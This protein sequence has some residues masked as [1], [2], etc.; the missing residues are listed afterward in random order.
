MGVFGYANGV[1]S[2]SQ[3]AD[4]TQSDSTLKAPVPLKGYVKEALKNIRF[5]GYYRFYGFHRN[6][7]VPFQFDSTGTNLLNNRVISSGD[8]YR[9]PMVFLTVTG[10]PT[11]KT[12]FYTDF[13]LY[14]PY[15]G[16]TTDNQFTLNLGINLYGNIE[17]DYGNF[18]L[19]AGGINWYNQSQL[20]I[21][22]PEAYQR[23][24]VFER[25]PWEPMNNQVDGR[26]DWY[27]QQGT[28][29]QGVRFG[30]RAMQGITLSGTNLPGKLGFSMLAGKTQQNTGITL[31]NYALS[32]RLYRY[33]GKQYNVLAYNHFTSITQTD[34]VLGNPRTYSLNTLEFDWK[35]KDIRFSGEA[36][37]GNY[38]SSTLDLG[39]GTAL[40]AKVT[41]PKKYTG[42][43][44]EFQ[45]YQI[46]PQFVNVNASFLNT[47]VLEVFAP[48][49]GIN[50][51][52]LTPFAGPITA[53]GFPTN[54]R[55]GFSLNTEAKLG[56]LKLNG[57]IGFSQEL[58]RGSSQITFDHRINGLQ[59]SRFALFTS[60]FGPYSRL[61]TY[62]RGLY[63]TVNI[64]DTDSLG[65]A[66]F[67]K[68]FAASDLQVKYQTALGKRSLYL[69]YMGSFNTG[70]RSFSP[71]PVGTDKAWIRALYNEMDVYFELVPDKVMLAGY[72]GLERIWGNLETDLDVDTGLPRN[73][74]GVGLGLGLDCKL[75]PNTGLYLRQ[76]WFEFKD[77]NFEKDHFSGT[78]S[79][80]ELKVYF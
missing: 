73:Q 25:V 48:I 31:P 16:N 51:T 24:S 35:W 9:E 63:E 55:R 20:T 10:Q 5:G 68:F 52:V 23:Y 38:T 59:W 67:D 77:P 39:L 44:M 47:S 33:F 70:Q 15:L 56:E 69:L 1:I 26:Y 64:T 54:N 79:T 65:N 42:L 50:A 72:G 30:R 7:K 37:L 6:M 46:D 8:G 71:I 60:N 75:A 45:F 18:A 4:S 57:G 49:E 17:T 27:Y 12:S 34:S 32:G 36:G 40:I 41:T 53:L 22:S 80:V 13:F 62:Y 74:T 19:Q 76:R 21:W 14:S 29:N 78:E 58:E 43:P 66:N 61:N 3:L 2:N 11:P 28:V